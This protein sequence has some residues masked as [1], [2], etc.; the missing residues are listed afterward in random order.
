MAKSVGQKRDQSIKIIGKRKS[1]YLAPKSEKEIQSSIA[2][3]D[4]K[5][6]SISTAL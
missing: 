4:P 2:G 6:N 3:C 5:I 1:F